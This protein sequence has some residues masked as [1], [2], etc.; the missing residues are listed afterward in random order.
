MTTLSEQVRQQ[1]T[2]DMVLAKCWWDNASVAD[3]KLV[4]DEIQREFM[5]PITEVMARF[6]QIGYTHVLL[7]YEKDMN[8]GSQLPES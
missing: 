4:W 5:H 6:A 7:E 2:E 8:V 1:Q 3:R